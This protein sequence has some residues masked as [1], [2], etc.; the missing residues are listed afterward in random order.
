MTLTDSDG[1]VVWDKE[2]LETYCSRFFSK[3][4]L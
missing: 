3:V 2:M 1:K 4:I